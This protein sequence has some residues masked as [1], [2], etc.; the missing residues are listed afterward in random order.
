MRIPFVS[1]FAPIVL[2]LSACRAQ[3]PAVT[4]AQPS[5]GAPQAAAPACITP[6]RSVDAL[7]ADWPSDRR[8]DLEIALRSNI[9]VVSATCG[10][11]RVLPNCS[12]D[13]TYA[14]LGTTERED[15]ISLQ[16]MEEVQVNLPL[17]APA[18][19]R[20]GGADF[21]HG[22]S[23]DVALVGI[24]RRTTARAS[25]LRG[26]LKGECDGAT[27][28]V[29]AATVGAFAV[30]AGAKG[31]TKTA[32]DVF[33][34]AGAKDGLLEA[35]RT[36]T[37][38]AE[39]AVAQCGAPIRLELAAIKDGGTTPSAVAA[40]HTQAEPPACPSG[41]VT[42]ETGACEKPSADRPH[43][44]EPSD[45][46]ECAA[47]CDRGS[48]GSCAILGRSYQLGRGVPKDLARA[49]ELFTKGCAAHAAPACGR[50]GEMALEA[51]DEQRGLSLL[52]DACSAGWIEGCKLS[53]K[54]MVEHP[55]ASGGNSRNIV[56]RA[57]LGGAPG[58]CWATGAMYANGSEASRDYA[59]AYRWFGMACEGAAKRGC[60]DYAR[61]ID[62]GQGTK[63]DPARAVAVLTKSCEVGTAD[64]CTTLSADYDTGHAVPKDA[65]KATALADRA[66]TLGDNETCT[67][68]G[69]RY[70]LGIGV[71]ANPAKGVEMLTKGCEGGI[72]PSCAALK[73]K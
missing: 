48:A 53:V 27:H 2:V 10:S 11:T 59:E 60:T 19:T 70:R 6:G 1:L 13:G 47:Q 28:Y 63:A 5:V 69:Q 7:V 29:R 64:A 62:A 22:G 9:V 37:P 51:H 61:L 65:G 32:A 4:A 72:A 31:Q 3:T 68:A 20:P 12:V 46:A 49:T 14:F 56:K 8:G 39:S 73:A 38:D 44:C 67:I 16:S 50:I 52:R 26:D 18:L 45:V 21:S 15:L 58:A 36:A 17:S 55:T 42:G 43:V 35:C 54:Y 24:G 71:P 57:C 25:V 66:C 34:H 33:A 40:S 30:A 23:V 41:M